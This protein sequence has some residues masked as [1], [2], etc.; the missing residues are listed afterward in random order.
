MCHAHYRRFLIYGD[1]NVTKTMQG[2]PPETRFWAKVNKTDSCWLWTGAIVRGYGVFTPVIPGPLLRAHRYSYE[3]LVGPI[4]DGL[5]IDHLCRTPLCVNPAHL[6]PVTPRENTLRG[7]TFQA[8]NL[9][10]THCV[11]GHEFTPEN[12]LLRKPSPRLPNG[13]RWCRTCCREKMRRRRAA[14]R[15][16]ALDLR[17][18]TGRR[19]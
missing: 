1:P 19:D 16:R 10:K 7:N 14:A 6:E 12:T 15:Q 13:G 11:N 18:A 17:I 9:A 4:P 2:K 5:Q 3:L 8:K